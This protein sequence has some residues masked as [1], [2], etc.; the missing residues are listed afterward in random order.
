MLLNRVILIFILVGFLRF[1]YWSLFNI[2]DSWDAGYI[3]LIK[4]KNVTPL[5]LQLFFPLSILSLFPFWKSIYTYMRSPDTDPHITGSV[6]FC[7]IFFSLH[8]SLDDFYWSAFKF[9]NFFLCML[10]IPFNYFLKCQTMYFSVSGF[11]SVPF[12]SLNIFWN[13]YLKFQY[14][15]HLSVCLYSL[16]FFL[17]VNHN[18]NF[19]VCPLIFNYWND[20]C[21]DSVFCILIL[22]SAK[23]L[24]KQPVKLLTDHHSFL[25]AWFYAL[26]ILFS[27][28]LSSRVN[29]SVLLYCVYS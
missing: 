8:F 1:I 23:F 3:F 20:N 12:K 24:L 4:C 13:S 28:S 17:T 19:F 15:D 7:P 9:P 16:S 21:R 5:F 10:L 22:K 26:L 6:H 2:L 18:K 29:S 25:G 11:T 14:L 27:F